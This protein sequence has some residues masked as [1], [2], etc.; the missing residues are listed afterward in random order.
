MLSEPLLPLGADA[1]R[2]LV[3]LAPHIVTLSCVWIILMDYS[4]LNSFEHH[5]NKY[6]I[7]ADVDN[8]FAAFR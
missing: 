4:Q 8:V 5:N 3:M 2:V 1:D 6:W 7:L